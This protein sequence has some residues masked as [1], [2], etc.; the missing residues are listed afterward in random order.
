MSNILK[1]YIENR[2]KLNSHTRIYYFKKIIFPL[3]ITIPLYWLALK[4]SLEIEHGSIATALL[5]ITAIIVAFLIFSMTILLTKENTK[6]VPNTKVKYIDILINNTEF[7]SILSMGTI[8][9]N[10]VYM[11]LSNL[12]ACPYVTLLN[13]VGFISMYVTILI[14]KIAIDDLLF[15]SKSYELS[16]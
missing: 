7:L 3:F 9:L 2:K 5:S 10:I 15:L 8:I 16:H 12:K 13:I 6:N 4:N 1:K 14:I 11:Y